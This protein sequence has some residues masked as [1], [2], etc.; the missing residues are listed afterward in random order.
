MENVGA[1]KIEIEYNPG[2]SNGSLR[3]NIDSQEFIDT[4]IAFTFALHR[5]DRL[6]ILVKQSLDFL[7]SAEFKE[8]IQS[9]GL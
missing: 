3:V 8:I 4:M 7:V 9:G 6:R 2:K 5:D 1:V